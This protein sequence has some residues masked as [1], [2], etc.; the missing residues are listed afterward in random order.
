MPRPGNFCKSSSRRG[1]LRAADV[2]FISCSNRKINERNSHHVRTI[3]G[4]G[5]PSILQGIAP[6]GAVC[7][8]DPCPIPSL[9]VQFPQFSGQVE[10]FS[11]CTRHFLA[12]K[13]TNGSV[14]VHNK[15][16]HICVQSVA[17][18]SFTDQLSVLGQSRELLAVGAKAQL[19]CPFKVVRRVHSGVRCT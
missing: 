1:T 3:R 16:H 8:R 13:Y 10:P 9:E 6:M 11:W 19:I 17:D 2:A 7:Q 12:L 5:N 15:D 4:T 14:R 18:G